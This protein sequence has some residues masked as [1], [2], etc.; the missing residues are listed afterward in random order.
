M[1]TV[2][3]LTN[4][5]D[6]QMVHDFIM[7]VLDRFVR[8]SVIEKTDI[9]VL[10]VIATEL[11]EDEVEEFIEAGA[12]MV[13]NGLIN[14]R[15][16]FTITLNR[17]SVNVASDILKRLKDFLHLLAHEMVHVKQYVNHELFDYTDG[18]RA[19]FN[20]EVYPVSQSKTMDQLYYES[21]WELEAYGR[22]TGLRDL[23]LI[24]K[25]WEDK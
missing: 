11:P 12:W 5:A 13:H 9:K 7:F 4:R 24:S 2:K 14:G 6:R 16:K 1:I 25:G 3:G 15:R 23:F 22:A 20:G 18:L 17:E 21:P 10:A 8:P 19:R